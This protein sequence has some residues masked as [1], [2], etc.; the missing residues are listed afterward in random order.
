MKLTEEQ[1]ASYREKGWVVV[2]GV[3]SKDEL[4]VVEGA[5]RKIAG[6]R[7]EGHTEVFYGLHLKDERFKSLVRHPALVEPT[8]QL[9]ENDIYVMNSRV[10]LK[11]T[12]GTVMKWHQDFGTFHR[13]DGVPEPR[14]VMSAVF[15]DEVNAC[16]APLLAIPGSHRE[17]L[18][19]A[20][21]TDPD[22]PASTGGKYRFDI[23]AETLDRLVKK[24]GLEAITGP[25]G[26]ML[27]M[28]MTVVHGSSINITP[29]RRIIVYIN[30]NAIDNR[31]NT[32]AR[33]E[34][35]SARDFN[36][37]QAQERDCLLRH[38]AA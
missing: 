34:D 4:G 17:G 21:Q 3:L 14:G 20:I 10:N 24:Y 31:G 30:Y 37:V 15:L 18:V 27:Y 29:L 5:I 23:P 1:M 22:G 32:F 28:D 8:R 9:L 38:M 16:N 7:Q 2:P 25:A 33:P 35:Y 36:A 6:D 13:L 11:H 12:G 19:E 26:S